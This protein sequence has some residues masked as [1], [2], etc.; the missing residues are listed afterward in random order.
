MLG[1]FVAFAATGYFSGFGAVTAEVYP[2]SIRA[3]AQGFTYNIG[4]LASAAAPVPGRHARRHARLRRRAARLFGRVRRGGGV[5][6]L[7]SRNERESAD[8]TT[9]AV[10]PAPLAADRS[11]HAAD[12]RAAGHALAGG[13]H[14]AAPRTSTRATNCWR[15]RRR[16]FRITYDA[17]GRHAGREG[18]LQRDPQR[19]PGERPVG[20][21]PD[22]RRAARGQGS[23]RSAGARRGVEGRGRARPTTSRSQLARPVPDGGEVR[24]RIHKTYKDADELPPRG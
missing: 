19:H 14:R 16:R 8:M 15:R 23:H 5:L 10:R 9:H 21:R 11:V 20:D 12:Y 18:L 17:D 24:I 13:R 2:T 6:D 4:R 3:T 7:D 1:P 22:D